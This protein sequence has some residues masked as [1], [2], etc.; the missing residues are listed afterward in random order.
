VSTAGIIMEL[1][2]EDK[3][4]LAALSSEESTL[5]LV[6]TTISA[7]VARPLEALRPGGT[8]QYAFC[9]LWQPAAASATRGL[10]RLVRQSCEGGVPTQLLRDLEITLL[11]RFCALGQHALAE[12]F[13][14]AR[15]L[16]PVLLAHI[17]PEHGDGQS[18]PREYYQTFIETHRQDGLSAMLCAYPV[19]ARHIPREVMRW[20]QSSLETIRRV[21]G[22]RTHLWRT[23]GVP[24][25]SALMSLRPGLGDPHRG[26]R[27][28]TRIVFE[29]GGKGWR[30]VYK[31]RCLA[32]E[33]EFQGLIAQAHSA[34]LPPLRS[35]H[36][37]VRGSYGYVEWIERKPCKSARDIASFYR[38]AGRLSSLLYILGCTDCHERNLIAYEDQLVVVDAETLFEPP[39]SADVR[40]GALLKPASGSTS[41][42]YDDSVARCGILPN[43]HLAGVDYH[44][45]DTSALGPPAGRPVKY[46]CASW[47][48]VNTDWMC[49]RERELPAKPAD[50]SP[51][52]SGLPNPFFQHVGIFCDGFVDQCNLMIE[53]RPEWLRPNG[54][55]DRFAGLQRRM[56]LRPTY[57]YATILA[58]MLQPEALRSELAQRSTLD[59]LAKLY[60]NAPERPRDW[61][62]L[63][64]EQRQMSSLD[65]PYFSHLVNSTDITLNKVV[66]VENYFVMNGL[67]E[68]RRRLCS[69][70][71]TTIQSQLR[72]IQATVTAALS[73][74]QT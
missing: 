58:Q 71:E 23:F 74:G 42:P 53:Q 20:S 59:Q 13:Q 67:D 10:A 12:M 66:R 39:P 61:P 49:W 16:G 65:I 47:A 30:L 9:D 3:Q 11:E 52:D 14:L 54:L 29:D 46:Q 1:E 62:V 24:P 4:W 32:L 36:S 7:A 33:A 31:P 19:L 35:A 55:I 51:V 34:D 28:T 6:R 43:Q 69:L 60:L 27:T 22:D 38:N 72:I 45:Y 25:D 64:E 57:V 41:S 50:S 56:V 73:G 5:A 63:A 68:C 18:P 15:G 44:P 2:N 21:N 37:L 48:N 26:G 40:K 70:N 17:R 8:G